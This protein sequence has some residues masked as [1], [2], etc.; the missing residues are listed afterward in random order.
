MIATTFFV[1]EDQL[2]WL[3]ETPEGISRTLRDL[4]DQQ[5]AKEAQSTNTL[6]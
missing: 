3:R 5:M 1:R 4:I 2:Q 6:E